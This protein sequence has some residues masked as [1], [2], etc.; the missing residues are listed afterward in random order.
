MRTLSLTPCATHSNNINIT[1]NTS[2]WTWLWIVQHQ[3]DKKLQGT[4]LILQCVDYVHLESSCVLILQPC[5]LVFLHKLESCIDKWYQA[6]RGSQAGVG[7]KQLNTNWAQKNNRRLIV[8]GAT[9]LP[10]LVWTMYGWRL[11]HVARVWAIYHQFIAIDKQLQLQLASPST[12]FMTPPILG[13]VQVPSK[14]LF[15]ATN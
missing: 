8:F 6:G 2:M 4:C 1:S 12:A 15:L 14:C 11:G 9:S 7:A 3:S 13:L 5:T 10:K